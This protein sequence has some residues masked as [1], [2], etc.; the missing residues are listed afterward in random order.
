MAKG[1][2]IGVDNKARKVKRMYV[3]VNGV[4]RKIKKAYIGVG[5]VARLCY[6]SGG[7]V[8]CGTNDNTQVVLPG[9]GSSPSYAYFGGG[10]TAAYAT[11]VSTGV[12]RY[13]TSLTFTSAD[14]LSLGRMSVGGCTT[15]NNEYV[16]FAGGS[17][18]ASLTEQV[19][20]VDI[21]SKSLTSLT[22]TSLS[23]A[24]W[25]VIT[26]KAGA[27]YSVFA[28][29]FAKSG[30]ASKTAEAFNSSLSKLAAP[31]L[32]TT[33]QILSSASVGNY[34]LF[35]GGYTTST[36][37]L[38][39]SYTYDA[40]VDVYNTSL[41]HS[42]TSL[43][44]GRK[45][46]AGAR[47]GNYALFAGGDIRSSSSSKALSDRVDAYN[48]SL[49]RTTASLSSARY[50]LTGA[51]N[52]YYALFVGGYDGS[53]YYTIVDIY[54]TSLTRTIGTPITTARGSMYSAT[55]G[56]YLLFTGG[57]IG[58]STKNTEIFMCVPD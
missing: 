49:T 43:S 40:I 41:T 7:V 31:N 50:N 15:P 8:Y 29:G 5:G 27:S 9:T 26:A 54:D 51:G 4:A 21:I 22:P 30:G 10:M 12:H 23:V 42:T 14:V 55:V 46:F 11:G 28:G 18:G 44:V 34:A 45:D 58:A 39:T 1:V 48:T 36:S 25:T 56:N 38:T 24:K 3:G 37:G 20:T 6:S 16:I 52:D 35:A 13:D 2:Y 19:N 32:S 57:Q 53:N 33:G 17:N 47:V